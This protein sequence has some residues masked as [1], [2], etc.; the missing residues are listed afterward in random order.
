MHINK[1][2]KKVVGHKIAL[3]CFHPY[4]INAGLPQWPPCIFALQLNPKVGRIVSKT[5]QGLG[6]HRFNDQAGAI[7]QMVFNAHINFLAG[8]Y[9][10]LHQPQPPKP[11][12]WE[13]NAVAHATAKA[14]FLPNVRLYFD[15]LIHAPASFPRASPFAP[16]QHIAPLPPL[17]PSASCSLRQSWCRWLLRHQA[18]R[19][20]NL[21][22]CH[23]F[24]MTGAR[25]AG[26]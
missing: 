14:F 26:P 23:Q 12:N 20:T 2:V 25:R 19:C 24:P 10:C 4:R 13:L 17:P 5:K 8:F 9:A 18:K 11:Q 22:Q 1:A 7:Q 21:L 6:L 16:V 15:L 3:I